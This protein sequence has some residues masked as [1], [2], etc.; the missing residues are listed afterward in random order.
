MPLSAKR[1]MVSKAESTIGLTKQC[2]L[3]QIHRSGIYY[4]PRGES[5][6]NLELM[7][8]MDEHYLDHPYK[9]APQMFSWL[10]KDKGYQIN[11]KRIERLYYKVMGLRAL[12]PGPHT[13]RRNKRHKVYP[14]LL[15]D[16]KVN[17]PNQVW[18]IDITYIPMERGFM[19]LVAIIDVYTRYIIN[20]SVSNN[21]DTEWVC[22]C[23]EEAFDRY[24]RPEIVNTD[25]G[26]Q[27]TSEK[28]TD[29]ILQ[30]GQTR[31]SMDGKGR[32]TDNAY[33]E[34][35]WRTLKYE[36]IYLNPARD[37]LDLY[38]NIRDYVDYYNHR[39]RHSRIDD[40]RPIDLFTNRQ[41]KAVA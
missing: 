5:A 9:G 3:L 4:R 7:R 40:N 10:N 13:T 41:L 12:Q 32:A 18:Q 11:P 38:S 24:G 1:N 17:R 16:L 36:K 8:L 39:R 6:L 21:M 35:F 34:R 31:L 26:S 15:K 33:I 22:S 23:M 19:Y 2:E 29:L 28:F 14:Y 27:F 20:W 37:G 30:G 25:Q